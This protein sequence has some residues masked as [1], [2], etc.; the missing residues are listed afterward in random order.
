LMRWEDWTF[1]LALGTATLLFATALNLV[2][3]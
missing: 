2:S 1:L 3:Q